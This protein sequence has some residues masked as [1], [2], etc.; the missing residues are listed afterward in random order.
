MLN[1]TTK[2][3]YAVEQEENWK[4][5]SYTLPIINFPVSW[6]VQILMPWGGAAVRFLINGKISVYLD[7]WKRLGGDENYWE[8]CPDKNGETTRYTMNN[9][10]DLIKGIS[11]SIRVINK[12]KKEQSK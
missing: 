9:V 8:I 3:R 11:A 6:S 7:L 1:Q 4:L 5:L 2:S 12:T 10:A